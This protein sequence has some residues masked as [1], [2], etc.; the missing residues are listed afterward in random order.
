LFQR[1][2]DN[3]ATFRRKTGKQDRGTVRSRSVIAESRG[4]IAFTTAPEDEGVL[5][6][7]VQSLR[8]SEGTPVRFSLDI[9]MMPFVPEEI[10]QEKRK[11]NDQIV[12]GHVSRIESDIKGCE[13]KLQM[14]MNTGDFLKEKEIGVHSQSISMNNASA[15]WPMFHV[16]VLIIAGYVQANHIA[17]F[18]KKHHIV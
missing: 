13:R 6:I 9:S 12:D 4:S 14:I 5:E 1:F 8:A 2:T 18:F 7:C 15:Y 3:T 16:V 17:K 11:R 10:K